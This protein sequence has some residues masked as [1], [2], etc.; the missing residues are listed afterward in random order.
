VTDCAL[1]P[2]NELGRRIDAVNPAPLHDQDKA[3][4]QARA[5]APPN[6]D[7]GLGA[8]GHDSHIGRCVQICL[9]AEMSKQVESSCCTL[10][11]L[12]IYLCG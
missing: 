12:A 1:S 2:Q 11:D 9:K 5:D 7:D 3:R 4:G 6:G 10:L 8:E